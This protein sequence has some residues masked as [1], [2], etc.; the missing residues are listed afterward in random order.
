MFMN[1]PLVNKCIL[2]PLFFIII[3]TLRNRVGQISSLKVHSRLTNVQKL[4]AKHKNP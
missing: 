1:Y 3:I 4:V 2:I